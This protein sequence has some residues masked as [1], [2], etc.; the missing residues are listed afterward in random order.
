MNLYYKEQFRDVKELIIEDSDAS[1]V[2][3]FD[4]FV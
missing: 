2:Y 3:G 1:D 4:F